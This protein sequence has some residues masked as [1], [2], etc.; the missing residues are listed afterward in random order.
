MEVLLTLLV[1]VLVIAV[2]Y[3]AIKELGAAFGL[4]AQ[5]L[6]VAYVAV[7][8]FGVYFMVQKTGLL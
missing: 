2:V 7:V 4:P 5:I 1:V 3:W 6:T 8:L